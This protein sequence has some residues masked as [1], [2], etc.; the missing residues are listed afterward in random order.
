MISL[1]RIC[2]FVLRRTCAEC[3]NTTFS[4]STFSSSTFSSSTNHQVP[5][6]DEKCYNCGV[7]SRWTTDLDGAKYGDTSQDK[8]KKGLV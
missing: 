7:E 3:G 1:I 8:K 6:Q 5:V 4:S 2:F